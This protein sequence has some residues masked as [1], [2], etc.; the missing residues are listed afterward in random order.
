MQFHVHV[1]HVQDPAI[2][3]ELERLNN[4]LE[5][6][7]SDIDD[8]VTLLT[9][10]LTA[11]KTQ[12]DGIATLLTSIKHQLADALRGETLSPAA[13][14][15]LAAIMPALEAN[16]TEITDAI[17]ANT[18]PAAPAPPAPTPDAVPPAPKPVTAIGGDL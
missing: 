17:N 10:R 3:R 18:D 9:S 15:K 16:T 11:Q 7:M 5:I 2:A 4:N 14:D 13:R 1:I 6:F 8:F 12:V